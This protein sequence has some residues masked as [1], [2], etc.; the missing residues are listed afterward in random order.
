MSKRAN[1][2]LVET[3]EKIVERG[4]RSGLTY[5]IMVANLASVALETYRAAPEDPFKRLLAEVAE[6]P[7]T[8][9]MWK[10]SFSS[11]TCFGWEGDQHVS[12]DQWCL[13]CRARLALKKDVE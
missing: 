8:T 2:V 4:A 5:G 3:L 7:C 1:K 6:L 9:P 12:T 10:D 13:R 11:S